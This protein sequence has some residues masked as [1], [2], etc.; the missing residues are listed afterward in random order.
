MKTENATLE[1]DPTER[2]LSDIAYI[3]LQWLEAREGIPR[4][5]IM[6][7]L[8]HAAFTEA[9]GANVKPLTA[10]PHTSLSE[11]TVTLL[12]A[13][14]ALTIPMTAYSLGVQTGISSRRIGKMLA[15]AGWPMKT[16]AGTTYW[17]PREQS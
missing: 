10:R 13:A 17:M 8:I 6:E 11:D 15:D 1:I 4:E 14:Q 7:R 5:T 9:T 3:E 12:E 2:A 16:H